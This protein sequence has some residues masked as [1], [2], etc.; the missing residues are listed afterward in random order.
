ML[1]L[2]GRA[3]WRGDAVL[4]RNGQLEDLK[5]CSIKSDEIFVDEPISS[6][7]IIVRK[8]LEHVADAFVAPV[9]DSLSVSS[10]DE[11]KVKRAFVCCQSSEKPFV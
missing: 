3:Q 11:K 1:H 7:D 5:S 4:W 2:V 10:E 6:L 8:Q 9:A